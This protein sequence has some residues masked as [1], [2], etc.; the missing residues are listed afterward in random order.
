M[1]EQTERRA[2]SSTLSLGPVPVY[3]NF[4]GEI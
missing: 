3:L 4:N 2:L 1:L